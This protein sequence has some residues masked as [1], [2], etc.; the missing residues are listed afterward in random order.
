VGASDGPHRTQG[1]DA[2]DYQTFAG[3]V[4]PYGLHPLH[5][6]AY[7]GN[8]YVLARNAEKDQIETFALSRFRGIEA[9]GSTFTRPA[10]FDA[11]A[12]PRKPSGSPAVRNRSR[13]GCSSNRKDGVLQVGES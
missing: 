10:D 8:W 3:R 9:A 11:P 4:S 12:L 1:S 7:H 2:A 13:C 5:L 6:L